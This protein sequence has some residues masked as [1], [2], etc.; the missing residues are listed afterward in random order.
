MIL[1]G[2]SYAL[3][4]FFLPHYSM[5]TTFYADSIK[6]GTE[7]SKNLTFVGT[8]HRIRSVTFIVKRTCNT[9]L[10]LTKREFESI[11]YKDVKNTSLP[12]VVEE[13]FESCSRGR[14]L[15]RRE[16]SV[17][18]DDISLP[19]KHTKNLKCDH[20]DIMTLMT[21]V[22]NKAK[23]MGFRLNQYKHRVFVLPRQSNCTYAA[24]ASMGCAK[25][26]RIWING[27]LPPEANVPILIHELGHNLGL[28]HSSTLSY[29][30]GDGSCVMGNS[31]KSCFNAI[32]QWRLNWTQPVGVINTWL[33]RN[34][35]NVTYILSGL[36]DSERTFVLVYVDRQKQ[37]YYA[38]SYRRASGG[39]VESLLED[40]FNMRVSVHKAT[41]G[42]NTYLVSNKTLGVG[43]T[44][45]IDEIG[46]AVLFEGISMENAVVVLSKLNK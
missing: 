20:D 39:I 34:G 37:S 29:E 1:F 9:T 17:M 40:V 21:H 15:F 23:L 24:L 22:E 18:F 43:E 41:V 14:T 28:F 5:G 11:L 42:S 2:F 26:C 7:T 4:V 31:Y 27:I 38:V 46:L 35:T 3:F 12:F 8:P 33:M 30:Y 44:T 19:C 16:D 13:F 32:Q 45:I 36:L 10:Q 25:Y 6:T